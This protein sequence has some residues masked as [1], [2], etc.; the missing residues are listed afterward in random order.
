MVR[1]Q[2]AHSR[3]TVVASLLA[4]SAMLGS[5][6]SLA[7]TIDQ[8]VRGWSFLEPLGGT[9]LYSVTSYIMGKDKGPTLFRWTPGRAALLVQVSVTPFIDRFELRDGTLW[10]SNGRKSA[11][12]IP[13]TIDGP[14]RIRVRNAWKG[15]DRLIEKSPTRFSMWLEKSGVAGAK[16]V[17]ATEFSALDHDNEKQMLLLESYEKALS[18]KFGTAS[19]DAEAISLTASSSATQGAPSPS[20]PPD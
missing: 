8:P 11:L 20:R 13:A 17:M 6:A 16:P 14:G 7:T 1:T 18:K 5:A 2:I 10:W 9:S 15:Y 19:P 12:A 3:R 4:A